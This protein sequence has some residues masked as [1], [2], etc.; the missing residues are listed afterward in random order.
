NGAPT[1]DAPTS[2]I[3]TSGWGGGGPGGPGGGEPPQ[4]A[5]GRYEHGG[6]PYPPATGAGDPAPRRRRGPIIAAAVGVLVL[7]AGVLG[8]VFLRGPAATPPPDAAPRPSA[9]VL[10]P[11][12]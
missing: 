4:D 10:P 12:A 5:Y 8:Y 2:R 6:P 3:D 7:L 1:Y 11:P 9:L